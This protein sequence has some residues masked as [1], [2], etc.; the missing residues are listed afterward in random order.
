M[1]KR[2]CSNGLTQEKRVIVA[3]FRRISRYSKR[4]LVQFILYFN[5]E[6]RALIGP[7]LVHLREAPYLSRKASLS[8]L[9]RHTGQISSILTV[10]KKSMCDGYLALVFDRIANI[11]HKSF[12]SSFYVRTYYTVRSHSWMNLSYHWKITSLGFQ[13]QACS[14]WFLL[15]LVTSYVSSHLFFSETCC[16]CLRVLQKNIS[17]IHRSCHPSSIVLLVPHASFSPAPWVSSS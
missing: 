17:K 9:S 2:C 6:I 15:K 16:K 11:S 3:T 8:M 7:R 5:S 1:R 10:H 14:S 12:N 13:R 4:K